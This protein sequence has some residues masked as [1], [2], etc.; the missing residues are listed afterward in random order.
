MQCAH[1]KKINLNVLNWICTYYLNI[2]TITPSP[3]V[4][5]SPSSSWSAIRHHRHRHISNVCT[6]FISRWKAHRSMWSLSFVVAVDRLKLWYF[7][8]FVFVFVSLVSWFFVYVA[9]NLFWAF[10][11][12]MFM[13]CCVYFFTDVGQRMHGT[14]RPSV[15]P[16]SFIYLLVC[17]DSRVDVVFGVGQGWNWVIRTE[18]AKYRLKQ[19]QVVTDIWTLQ[20]KIFGSN[21]NLRIYFFSPSHRIFATLNRNGHIQFNGKIK[22]LLNARENR[23]VGETCE[24]NNH[25]KQP[26]PQP[27]REDEL[28]TVSD[29]IASIYHHNVADQS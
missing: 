19:T 28:Q 8:G 21:C 1:N 13:V 12:Q 25:E 15:R 5:L 6:C 3:L 23:R 9:C 18:L 10:Q 2:I 16:L 7:Y 4:P 14:V 22:Q 11:H 17:G 26:A 20:T 29:F 24:D 27:K